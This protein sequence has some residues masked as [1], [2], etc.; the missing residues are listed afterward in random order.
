[1]LDWHFQRG[2]NVLQKRRPDDRLDVVVTVDR[3]LVP[4][5]PAALAG[6]DSVD[7]G[8]EQPSPKFVRQLTVLAL[9]VCQAKDR[10][11]ADQAAVAS[12]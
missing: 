12:M 9:I 2:R 8:L 10:D 4:A 1:M 3:L 5:S 11:V 7:P 6:A